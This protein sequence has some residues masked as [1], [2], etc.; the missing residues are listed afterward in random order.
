MYS[1]KAPRLAFSTKG[2]NPGQMLSRAT[3]PVFLMAFLAEC[4]E[5]FRFRPIPSGTSSFPSSSSSPER[6]KF[7]SVRRRRSFD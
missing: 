3:T 6:L 5:A 2:S 4:E 7:L 1:L